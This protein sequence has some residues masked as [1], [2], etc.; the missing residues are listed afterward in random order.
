MAGAF[1]GTTLANLA[2]TAF[3]TALAGATVIT[4]ALDGA[5]FVRAALAGAFAGAACV[6]AVAG[7][8]LAGTVAALAAA[9]FEEAYERSLG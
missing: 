7:F 4:V 3:G 5:A 8:A 6:G 2:K 1:V 9:A